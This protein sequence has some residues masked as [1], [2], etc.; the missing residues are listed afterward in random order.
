M[1]EGGGSK[2]DAI[3][4]AVDAAE[5]EEE[6]EE[7]DASAVRAPRTECSLWA[8]PRIGGFRPAAPPSMRCRLL[9]A[10]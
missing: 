1:L 8:L 9:V 3:A 7:M 4:A 2:E 10:R 6:K 5:A